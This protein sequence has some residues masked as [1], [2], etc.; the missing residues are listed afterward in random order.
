[1]AKKV[2]FVVFL[3]SHFSFAQLVNIES[4]RMQTDSIRFVLKSD[5]TFSYNNND[6]DYIYQIGGAL[7]TQLKSKDLKKTYFLIGNYKLIRAEE[8]DFQN[9]WFAHF[10]FNFKLSR[11]IRAESFIQSQHNELLDINSRHL[12]GAGIR[13]KLISKEHVKL[14]L[15]N[16]YMYEEEQSDG[17]NKRFY[18]HRH[19]SYLSISATFNE[20]KL[21]LLNTLYYQ[22]LYSDFDNYRILEQFKAEIPIS[23][24]LNLFTLFNYYLDSLTPEDNRQYTS[25]ISFGIGWQL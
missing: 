2:L 1:M 5:A 10:R 14:Y 8:K 4:K 21:N 20:S 25:N 9:S 15:G 6:G 3:V 12:I 18:N 7:T 11:M 13:L 23:K 16:A 17:F 24:S 22:P 19:S